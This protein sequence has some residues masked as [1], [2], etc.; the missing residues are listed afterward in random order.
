[1][2]TDADALVE[3]IFSD[4]AQRGGQMAEEPSPHKRGRK[5]HLFT[6]T[7]EELLRYIAGETFLHGGV[8]CS[9]RELAARLRR[10]VKTIE[11]SISDLRNRGVVS[12]EMRYD[13]SG[14][15]VPSLYRVVIDQTPGK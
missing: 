7:E 8:C 5:R 15:Q 10:N 13:E 12:V 14:G 4:A 2:R 11:R 6:P 9:K 3:K 1:M